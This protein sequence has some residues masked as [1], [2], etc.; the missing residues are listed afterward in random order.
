[1][2]D[3]STNQVTALTLGMFLFPN[4][5]ADTAEKRFRR[6]A[7]VVFVGQRTKNDRW[8]YS[9]QSDADKLEVVRVIA[10]IMRSAKSIGGNPAPKVGAEHDA[11]LG[12]A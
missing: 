2:V 10:Q 11:E 8:L 1:M 7:R 6:I 4:L 5:R 12:L 9:A 3:K